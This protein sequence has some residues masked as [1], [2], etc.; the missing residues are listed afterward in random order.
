MWLCVVL[1]EAWKVIHHQLN[2][3]SCLVEKLTSVHAFFFVVSWR[4]V[5]L[6]LDHG[7][8]KILCMKYPHG[9]LPLVPCHWPAWYLS[10][11]LC[12]HR[13][14]GRPIALVSDGG[15]THAIEL[16]LGS[17][18]TAVVLGSTTC[19]LV[20]N[21]SDQNWRSML[22]QICVMHTISADHGLSGYVLC[23]VEF[24]ISH[25]ILPLTKKRIS[26]YC[27]KIEVVKIKKNSWPYLHN[28]CI[29]TWPM[30]IS[31][32]VLLLVLYNGVSVKSRIQ[33]WCTLAEDD[34]CKFIVFMKVHGRFT[35]HKHC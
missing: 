9:A 20:G 1:P 15:K 5:H 6:L 31:L 4:S 29:Q 18:D 14:H 23:V 17:G 19:N 34:I 32:K 11:A 8:R 22:Q 27:K 7:H 12:C 30:S 25:V 2:L 13:G 35:G 10:Y 21:G 33:L 3:V 24:K 16:N 26:A 28:R